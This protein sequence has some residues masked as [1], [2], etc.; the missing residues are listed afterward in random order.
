M[1]KAIKAEKKENGSKVAPIAPPKGVGK[2]G[3][4]K[5]DL[6][7]KAG[8]AAKEVG[9]RKKG[10]A[11]KDESSSEESSEEEEEESGSEES[12]ESESESEEEEDEVKP[13]VKKAAANGSK[14]AT[15]CEEG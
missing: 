10:V 15:A 13:D 8:T 1:G 14:A 7:A 11:K 3:S 12:S 6:K 4:K 9:S 5:G 2:T